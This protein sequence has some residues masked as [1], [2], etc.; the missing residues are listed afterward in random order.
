MNLKSI[1]KLIGEIV[2]LTG[3]HIGGNKDTV[4]IGGIDSPVI[5][6]PKTK[7]PYIPGSTIK[8]K[9]RFWMEWQING[10]V[11]TKKG[12][13]HGCSNSNCQICR[14]FGTT[15]KNKNYGPTRISVMDADLCE[16][17]EEY[18]LD[19]LWEL[20]DKV[21]NRINR[22][23][24]AAKD[25]RHTERVPAGIR[26]KFAMS[27]KI[28]EID[29]EQKEKNGET[30]DEQF[31]PYVVDALYFLQEEG[32]GGSVSRGYGRFEFQNMKLNNESFQLVPQGKF[33]QMGCAL[34]DRTHHTG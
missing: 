20:E 21:E 17:D 19:G 10:K 34:D 30:I 7:M 12:E 13:P 1:N 15:D 18:Y 22:L 5:K 28:F 6:H 11:D 23:S 14:I 32:L 2:L 26:F 29:S 25:P 27:Y 24:G 3:M 33:V 16:T 8:G 4:E 9:M 31:W